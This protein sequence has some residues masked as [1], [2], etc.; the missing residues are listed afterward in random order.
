MP[1]P[2]ILDEKLIIVPPECPPPLIIEKPKKPK[3]KKKKIKAA[4]LE[5]EE[6]SSVPKA[7]V[8][9]KNMP[10]LPE[11]VNILWQEGQNKLE[12]Q[13]SKGNKRMS[14]RQSIL[15]AL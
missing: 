3:V 13:G 15:V 5:F 2:P 6:G 9:F 14:K 8:L 12:K 7:P 11:S 4:V 1:P 10:A